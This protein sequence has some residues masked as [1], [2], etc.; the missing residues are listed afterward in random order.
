MP[1]PMPIHADSIG[2]GAPVLKKVGNKLFFK[3]IKSTSDRLLIGDDGNTLTLDVAEP[4][5]ELKQHILDDTIKTPTDVQ[6]VPVGGDGVSGTVGNIVLDKQVFGKKSYHGGGGA[7]G[8]DS[9]FHSNS[10]DHANTLDHSNSLDHAQN[11]D[12]GTNAVSFSVNGSAVILAGNAA[13]TDARVPTT[14]GND[15]HSDSYTTLAAVK[16]DADVADAI[17][18]KHANTSDHA[19]NTDTGTSSANFSINGTNAMK[20]GDAPTGHKASHIT[21]GGDIIASATTSAVGLAPAA[22]AP[23]AG[24]VNALGIANGETA[25]TMKPLVGATVGTANGVAAAG[26]GTTPA[27]DDHVHPENAILKSVLTEKGDVIYASA[28]NTPAALAHG[29]AGDV[30]TSGGHGAAPAWAA[31][32]AASFPTGMIVQFGG[33]SAPSGWKLCDG[34]A[35]SSADY[36]ALYAVIGTAFG[37]D[38]APN[39]N[40]PDL[41]QKFPRGKGAAETLGATGGTTAHTHSVTSNVTVANH[42]SHT[43]TGPSHQHNLSGGAATVHNHTYTEVVNHVHKETAGNGTSGNFKSWTTVDTS[44]AGTGASAAETA[45]DIS[46]ANPTGSAGATGTTANNAAGA[47]DNAGTGASGNENAT[48]THA[49]TNNAVTSGAASASVE[50][51]YV[52]LNF[53]IKT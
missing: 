42:G 38:G 28:A 27:R 21:G 1:P 33:A 48:Q 16:L 17:S 13:L 39:F 10:L 49:P 35:L 6:R 29:D 5:P 31:P 52:I 19:Q 8:N 44:S 12:T 32:G 45:C 9:R 20:V 26:T 34:S 36:A 11:T 37:G 40:L 30:L 47:T 46:T 23:A 50:P 51:P 53:I 2:D 3:K 15:K 22:T 14:H 43:H 7:A 25:Y 4:S 41:R 18:K 24:V